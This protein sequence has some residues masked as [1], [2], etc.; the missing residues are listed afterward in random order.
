MKTVTK[1]GME[2][3]ERTIFYFN[4]EDG[5][6]SKRPD[7]CSETVDHMITLDS[8]DILVKECKPVDHL[9]IED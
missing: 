2:K 5:L 1:N 9:R 6:I 3:E 4:K 8:G 7:G